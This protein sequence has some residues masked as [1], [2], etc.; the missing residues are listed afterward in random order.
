MRKI[1]FF[2][3]TI[4]RTIISIYHYTIIY[5]CYDAL[6]PI[7]LFDYTI[8]ITFS[9]TNGDKPTY[10]CYR[11]H[12]PKLRTIDTKLVTSGRRCLMSA[13]ECPECDAQLGG[14]AG[15]QI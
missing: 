12:I 2:T 9:S 6:I 14:V 10:S 7:K 4:L 3:H 5:A 13:K 1:K 8:Q 11:L 15:G